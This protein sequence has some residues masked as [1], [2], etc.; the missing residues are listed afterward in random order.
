M[1]RAYL[2]FT[3]TGNFTYE[4]GCSVDV[5][6]PSSM[7]DIWAAAHDQLFKEYLVKDR[8][9]TNE[10]WKFELVSIQK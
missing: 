9:Y 2:K 6:D 7:R 5:D 4:G 10:E 1:A 3:K 8:E